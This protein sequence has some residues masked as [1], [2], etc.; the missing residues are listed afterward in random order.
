MSHPCGWGELDINESALFGYEVAIFGVVLFH[1]LQKQIAKENNP[2]WDSKTSDEQQT[3]I[4][5]NWATFRS[6]FDPLDLWKVAL[7]QSEVLKYKKDLHDQGKPFN[8]IG[9]PEA[10]ILF[11]KNGDG[12]QLQ[13]LADT[14]PPWQGS[15]KNYRVKYRAFWT[16]K[17]DVTSDDVTWITT[18]WDFI[19][20]THHLKLDGIM[21]GVSRMTR[22]TVIGKPLGERFI[23]DPNAEEPD[24]NCEKCPFG[25]RYQDMK[26]LPCGIGEYQDELG[27]VQCKQCPPGEIG[28]KTNQFECTPCPVGTFSSEFGTSVCRRCVPNGNIHFYQNEV[29]QSSCKRCPNHAVCREE[30]GGEYE[31]FVIQYM[32]TPRY[33]RVPVPKEEEAQYPFGKLVECFAPET[34]LGEEVGL[35]NE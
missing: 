21:S 34:C 20:A 35:G 28:T 15:G 12:I 17:E 31:G 25:T 24:D 18:G 23:C 9:G 3:A 10:P 13:G 8:C 6:N 32:A 19:A 14:R 1:Q 33:F 7:D 30:T 2:D 26:C 5:D 4:N 11:E 22:A 27:Q 16:D 29:G